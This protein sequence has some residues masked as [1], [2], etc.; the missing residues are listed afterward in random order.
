ML[1]TV[2]LHKSSA[3][4]FLLLPGRN[5]KRQDWPCGG[6]AQR[7]KAQEL[8][9]GLCGR[10]PGHAGATRNKCTKRLAVVPVQLIQA[11]GEAGLLVWGRLTLWAGSPPSLSYVWAWDPN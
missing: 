3:A 4:V 9:D 7:A 1:E 10:V 2:G 11:H 8:K 6:P 5:V